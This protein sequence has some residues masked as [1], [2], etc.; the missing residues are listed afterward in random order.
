MS[1]RCPSCGQM[2]RISK[3]QRIV[4][5]KIGERLFF[6]GLDDGARGAIYRFAGER[7]RHVSVRSALGKGIFVTVNR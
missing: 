5:A 3:Y 1:Q 6:A 4:G 7:G 2:I